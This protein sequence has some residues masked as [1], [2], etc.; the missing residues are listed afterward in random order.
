[1]SKR[2]Q[3]PIHFDGGSFTAVKVEPGRDGLVRRESLVVGARALRI[4]GE[5]VADHPQFIRVTILLSKGARS[6]LLR[7]N[8]SL[9]VFDSESKAVR[10]FA[11]DTQSSVLVEVAVEV[12]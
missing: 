3:E 4:Q 9:E 5:P 10:T 6:I 7:E 8:S 12:R 2:N 1:M 11:L